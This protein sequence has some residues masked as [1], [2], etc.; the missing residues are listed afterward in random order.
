MSTENKTPI[1]FM[2]SVPNNHELDSGISK[3]WL[4]KRYQ[5]IDENHAM[6]EGERQ[7]WIITRH[8]TADL[9]FYDTQGNIYTEGTKYFNGV[10]VWKLVTEGQ[11]RVQYKSTLPEGQKQT[12]ATWVESEWELV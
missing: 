12:S 3:S 2:V 11:P 9:D 5:L 7:A 6:S 10:H 4:Y 1:I 8:A